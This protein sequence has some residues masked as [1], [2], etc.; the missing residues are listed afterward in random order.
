M[1]KVIAEIAVEHWK[2]LR[3]FERAIMAL[4]DD[5]RIR[6]QAQARYAAERLGFLLGREGLRIVDFDGKA[7][8]VNLPV[9]AINAD[10]IQD[11]ATATVERTL[12]PAVVSDQGVILSGKVYLSDASSKQ[13]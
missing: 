7:F 3:A 8:E 10:E 2:L 12:E 13:G 9:S 6:F 5:K 1:S 4:P 11:I